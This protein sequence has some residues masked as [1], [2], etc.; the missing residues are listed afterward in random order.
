MEM[1]GHP[2]WLRKLPL[3]TP[4]P[5]PLPVQIMSLRQTQSQ[6]EASIY[7]YCPG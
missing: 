1:V 3:K 2:A 6:C 5:V 4:R 7:A